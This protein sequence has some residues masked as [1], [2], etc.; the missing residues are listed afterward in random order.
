MG[1]TAIEYGDRTW[2][3]YPG[4]NGPDG[5]P[6]PYCWAQNRILPRMACEKCKTGKPHL[7]PERLQEPLHVKKPARWLVC[8]TGD[9]FGPWVE[10]FLIA[11]A[12]NIMRRCPQHTFLCLTKQPQNLARFSPFPSNCWVGCSVTNAE[13]QSAAYVGLGGIEAK[14]KYLSYEPLLSNVF[15][16]SQFLNDAGISWVVIGQQTPVKA[17][18]MPEV[19]WIEEIVKAA[20]KAGV[21]VFLKNNLDAILH[22]RWQDNVWGKLFRSEDESLRQEVP[23]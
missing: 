22:H 14:V 19:E 13:Q 21:K 2:N 6:C 9:L 5:K 8:F 1:K 18:T 23:K 20:D 12:L 10:P 4:C 16:E 15:M 7:H 11:E 17:S 3:F